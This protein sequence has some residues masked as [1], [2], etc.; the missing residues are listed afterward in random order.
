MIAE[1][2]QLMQLIYVLWFLRLVTYALFLGSLPI[3]KNAVENIICE[4]TNNLVAEA[5]FSL[6]YGLSGGEFKIPAYIILL[7]FIGFLIVQDDMHRHCQPVCCLLAIASLGG[8]TWSAEWI[9]GNMPF[10]I[11]VSIVIIGLWKPGLADDLLPEFI[12]KSRA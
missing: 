11:P 7:G 2:L 8:K 5:S 12:R 9:I 1:M 6:L 4:A 3:G 10:N